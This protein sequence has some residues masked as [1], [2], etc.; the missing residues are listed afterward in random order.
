MDFC[1][2]IVAFFHSC[3]STVCPKAVNFDIGPGE[4][5]S[6]AVDAAAMDAFFRMWG[7]TDDLKFPFDALKQTVDLDKSNKP[8]YFL[9]EI[10][11]PR[12]FFITF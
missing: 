11:R 6:V 4:T 12:Y 1:D 7:V 2:R 5:L 9:A 8:H 3:Y 10:C